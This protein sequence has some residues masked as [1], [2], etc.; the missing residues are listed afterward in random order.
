[1]KINQ[2]KAGAVLSYAILGLNNVIG[3]LYTPY[4]LRMM[5]QSEYGLY[6]LVASLLLLI[7]ARRGMEINLVQRMRSTALR[8][9]R[10]NAYGIACSP[11]GSPNGFSS[12]PA[13]PVGD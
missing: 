7:S 1:M 6:S 9:W 8:T 10:P 11:N 5:G 2:L 13:C 12:H 4:M 3:L